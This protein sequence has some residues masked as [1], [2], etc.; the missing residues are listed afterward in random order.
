MSSAWVELWGLGLVTALAVRPVTVWLGLGVRW[1]LMVS[2]V[3][4]A[5]VAGDL[6]SLR[7]RLPSPGLVFCFPSVKWGQDCLG[8]KVRWTSK[9]PARELLLLPRDLL[10][11]VQLKPTLPSLGVRP[12]S[13]DLSQSFTYVER[14]LCSDPAALPQS[15]FL[16]PRAPGRWSQAWEL[17]TLP[18]SLRH[19]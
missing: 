17:G 11:Q 8:E 18:Q 4:R 16:R 7:P 6:R 5:S 12:G 1:G 10:S 9:V 13:A 19:S 15:R 3:E 14:R 2:G